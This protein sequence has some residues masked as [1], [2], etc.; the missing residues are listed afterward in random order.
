KGQ[1][2]SFLAREYDLLVRVGGPNAGHKVFGDPPYTHH[3]L[4]SGTRYNTEARLLIGPGA[5]LNVDKLLV[6]IGDCGVDA[7]RLVID[8]RAM[9][10]AARDIRA[11]RK[12]VRDIGSTGSGTGAATA[13]RIMGR[14]SGTKLAG[15]EPRLR[16]YLGDAFRVLEDAYLNGQRV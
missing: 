6:E 14:H 13:R 9:V 8:R 15:D 4:P 1:I 10:I 2:V 7:G 11:E 3:Q 5:V 16:P 12:L